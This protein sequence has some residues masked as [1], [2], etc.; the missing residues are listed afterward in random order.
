MTLFIGMKVFLNSQFIGRLWNKLSFEGFSQLRENKQ[1]CNHLN[2]EN[3][4]E[5]SLSVSRAGV[6]GKM[7]WASFWHPHHCSGYGREVS[8]APHGACHVDPICQRATVHYESSSWEPLCSVL[9]GT[10]LGAP[11]WEVNLA[12]SLQR[13]LPEKL[14]MVLAG[15]KKSC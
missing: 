13:P 1:T 3:N 11:S 15:E 7:S 9:A 10:C 12:T 4:P 14:N 6:V 2:K 5:E 8:E